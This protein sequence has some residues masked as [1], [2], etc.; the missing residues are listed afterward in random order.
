MTNN[1]VYSRNFLIVMIIISYI[2]GVMLGYLMK[3]GF[4]FYSIIISSFI[5]LWFTLFIV[6]FILGKEIVT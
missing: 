1:K 5:G 4:T 2:L 6:P 3:D